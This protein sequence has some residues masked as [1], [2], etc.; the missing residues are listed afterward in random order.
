MSLRSAKHQYRQPFHKKTTIAHRNFTHIFYAG[1]ATAQS[2][3]NRRIT[4][5][6]GWIKN[7][8]FLLSMPFTR[9]KNYRDWN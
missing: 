8:T 4:G 9:Q 2:I 1:P 7:T 5:D 3:D 6:K